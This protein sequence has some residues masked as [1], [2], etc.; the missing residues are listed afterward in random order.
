M[1]RSVQAMAGTREVEKCLCGRHEFEEDVACERS[2]GHLY[3][4]TIV[5]AVVDLISPLDWKSVVLRSVHEGPHEGVQVA[6]PQTCR[7]VQKGIVAPDG[8]G[9]TKLPSNMFFDSLN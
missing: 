1:G 9:R 8:G 2:V 7:E 6:D 3:H 5:R 4:Q